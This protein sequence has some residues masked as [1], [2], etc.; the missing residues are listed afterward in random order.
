M[1][2]HADVR[3]VLESTIAALGDSLEL[4]INISGLYLNHKNGYFKKVYLSVE[5]TK[6]LVSLATVIRELYVE[7]PSRKDP[8]EA[9][10]AAETWAKEVFDPHVS[11]VYTSLAHFDTALV[12]TVKTRVE[13]YLNVM[14]IEV[15]QEGELQGYGYGWK[16]GVLKIVNCEGPVGEWEVLGSVDIHSSWK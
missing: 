8:Q 7:L 6:N 13:D 4:D 1:N 15:N 12:K 2:S 10:D 14:N 3:T 16:G 11:L 5:K 9:R